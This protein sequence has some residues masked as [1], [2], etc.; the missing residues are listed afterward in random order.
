MLF[1]RSIEILEEMEFHWV[2]IWVVARNDRARRFYERH[3]LR[4]DGAT[5]YDRFDGHGVLVVRLARM[6]NPAVDYD[7]I[8]RLLR[9]PRVPSRG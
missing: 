1:E 6:L 7:D 2:V 9:A 3:G 5:R 8:D 4:A